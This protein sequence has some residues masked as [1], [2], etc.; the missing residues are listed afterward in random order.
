MATALRTPPATHAPTISKARAPS[1]S[2]RRD[3]LRPTGTRGLQTDAGRGTGMMDY[4]ARAFLFRRL[5]RTRKKDPDLWAMVDRIRASV[6]EWELAEAEGFEGK[7]DETTKD[8]LDDFFKRPD[9]RHSF[10]D[11]L[12]VTGDRLK[13]V[14]DA[15]WLLR[16]AGDVRAEV[17]AR[18]ERFSRSLL[19]VPEAQGMSPRAAT[20]LTEALRKA[21]E[22]RTSGADD[23]QPIGFEFLQ[24]WVG[25]AKDP[26]Y[27]VQATGSRFMQQKQHPARDIVEFRTLDP[28]NAGPLGA[29]QAIEEWSDASIWAFMMNRD[30]V[31]TGNMADMILAVEGMSDAERDRLMQLMLE[32]ADPAS[33]DLTYVPMLI[34]LSRTLE[35]RPPVVESVVL[36]NKERDAT[37]SWMTGDI[38]K[39][40]SGVVG[41]PLP[42]TGEFQLLN[43]AA[44]QVLREAF[45]D[46]T[47]WPLF[48]SIGE[49]VDWRIVSEEFGAEDWTFG[50]KRPDFRTSEERHKQDMD[51]LEAGARTPRAMFEDLN[52]VDEANRVSDWLKSNGYREE[53][54]AL[55]WT[56]T[57]KGWVPI[58]E[59]VGKPE[60]EQAKAAAMLPPA[61]LAQGVVPGA[62]GDGNGEDETATNVPG[63]AAAEPPADL[64]KALAGLDA[65]QAECTKAAKQGDD[66]GA[67]WPDGWAVTDFPRRA[68]EDVESRLVAAETVTE[69]SDAFAPARRELR[70]EVSGETLD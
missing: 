26:E 48:R 15:H 4:Q 17:D 6:P 10:R 43:R 12:G 28:E 14:G 67:I 60:D 23:G 24:G 65:W 49:T 54:W 2:P 31:R 68:I 62:G 3:Y 41:T 55:P 39:Q 35:Q 70:K 25:R 20:V 66:P 33:T 16:R 56:K 22:E 42:L 7:A 59:V 38:R 57:G 1:P 50:F 53:V 69:V 19:A 46:F 34:R 5:M 52:G 61:A 9:G 45:D 37:W 21:V 30:S 13:S 29:M 63:Q 64:N 8:T 18:V 36:S 40:K 58:T 51:E 32:R 11:L 47:T 44:A 27:Y